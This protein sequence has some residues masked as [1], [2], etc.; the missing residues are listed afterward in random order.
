MFY[1][2][3][4]INHVTASKIV[5]AARKKKA[6]IFHLNNAVFAKLKP[7]WNKA[8]QAAWGSAFSKKG[9][10]FIGVAFNLKEVMTAGFAP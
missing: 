7:W 8:A 6:I 2:R 10:I 4:K 9:K 5:K 1:G 3:I